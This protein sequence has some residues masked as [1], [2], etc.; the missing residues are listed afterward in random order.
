MT[1]HNNE[2]FV[3]AIKVPKS[4]IF[5]GT[6]TWDYSLSHVEFNE[7]KRG[8]SEFLSV[9][10]SLALIGIGYAVPLASKFIEGGATAL[11]PGEWKVLGALFCV[12]LLIFV[13]GSMLPQISMF[14]PTEKGRTLRKIQRFF[15][16]NEPT[17]HAV[18]D[19]E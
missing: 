18:K 9:A 12:T 2:E 7:I 8:S 19:N 3:E 17:K 1:E 5:S 4:E 10:K 14:L 16:G 13:V 6:T 15:D 11:S